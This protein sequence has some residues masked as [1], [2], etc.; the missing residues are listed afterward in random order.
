MPR[1]P[2]KRN[3]LVS[4][5]PPVLE[6][7]L[8]EGSGQQDITLVEKL[9]SPAGTNQNFGIPSQLATC[10]ETSENAGKYK[11]QTPMAKTQ[12]YA[13]DSSPMGERG[14]T[15][16]RPVT[17]AR[18]YSSTLSVVGRKGDAGSKVPGTPAFESS[19]LSNFRRR[20]RQ[21][22]ILQMMQTDDGSSD[23]DDDVF[24]GGLSPEDESTPL[25]LSKGRSLL[26]GHRALPSPSFPA[27]SSGGLRK[28]K[29]PAEES[30]IPQF[31]AEDM[32]H[33]PDIS[34]G[35]SQ[36]HSKFGVSADS[37]RAP[38]APAAPSLMWEPPLSSSPPLSPTRTVSMP[39]TAQSKRM[40]MSAERVISK[41][42]GLP[43]SAL[44]HR[45]LPRRNN[46]QRKLLGI[47]NPK[48]PDDCTHGD[49]FVAEQNDGL[50]HLS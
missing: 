47:T 12:E 36:R 3:C 13:I 15:G 25:D 49:H 8:H 43:T 45:L 24:L 22:S 44:Q 50:Y 41:N 2:I 19:I 37:P 16:S 27:S 5:A 29:M 23:L 39:T 42:I 31:D 20:P 28:R 48:V 6:T 32:E 35:S 40:N 7:D 21:P 33:S 1:P 34:P 30:R 38:A 14:A 18:G 26:T 11:H 46:M 10:A 17:R 4:K 9:K